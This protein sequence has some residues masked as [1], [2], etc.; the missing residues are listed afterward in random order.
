MQIFEEQL[1]WRTS[2]NGYFWKCVYETEKNLKLFVRSFDFTLK[3]RF[4][5]DQYQKEDI[6]F[7]Y[8]L[9]QW[10]PMKFVFTYNVSNFKHFIFHNI[11]ILFHKIIYIA[12]SPNTIYLLELIKRRSIVWEK[13]MSC[14][15]A[16]NFDQ[17]KT[18]CKNYKPKRVWLSLVYKFTEN[19]CHLRRLFEFIQTQK[20]YPASLSYLS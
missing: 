11:K 20:R 9:L 7:Y 1:F 2:A 3:N 17:W 6:V 16:L 12:T 4:F 19:H 5:Q 15:H 18:F 8:F 14:E 13:N 10:F